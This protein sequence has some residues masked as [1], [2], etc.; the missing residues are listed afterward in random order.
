MHILM[1]IL[2]VI[3]LLV[4]SVYF[5]KNLKSKNCYQECSIFHFDGSSSHWELKEFS[6][7]L[8]DTIWFDSECYNDW[9]ICIDECLPGMCCQL[10]K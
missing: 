8:G 2:I 4:F 1:M 6:I 5:Y 9:C 7:D 3:I 10:L